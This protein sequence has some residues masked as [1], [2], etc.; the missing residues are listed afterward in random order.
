MASEKEKIGMEFVKTVAGE[1]A[2][3][4]LKESFENGF[5]ITIPSLGITIQKGQEV[6]E[7][8]TEKED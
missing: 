7:T 8:E 4:F 5:P 1:L 2:G 3:A 6:K